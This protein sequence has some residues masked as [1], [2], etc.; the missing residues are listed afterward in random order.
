MQ[1]GIVG[2]YW[3]PLITEG[4][5][6]GEVCLAGYVWE[7]YTHFPVLCKWLAPL[8][9]VPFLQ[10]GALVFHKIEALNSRKCY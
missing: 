6:L 8:S 1:F 5:A 10:I 2:S 4:Q 9:S 7:A 3:Q